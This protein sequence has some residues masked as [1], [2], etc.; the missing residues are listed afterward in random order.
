[1]NSSEEYLQSHNQHLHFEFED[2]DVQLL[3]HQEPMNFCV[4]IKRSSKTV[5]K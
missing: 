4:P 1:M 2:F 3:V 5:N